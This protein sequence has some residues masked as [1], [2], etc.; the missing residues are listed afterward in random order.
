MHRALRLAVGNMIANTWTEGLPEWSKIG[1]T[2]L[3]PKG[4]PTCVHHFRPI[5][6]LNIVYKWK[7]AIV[8]RRM[9]DQD[10]LSDEQWGFRR[11]RCTAQAVAELGLKMDAYKSGYVILVDFQRAYNSVIWQTLWN[12]LESIGANSVS[13]KVFKDL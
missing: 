1:V 13:I 2:R 12:Q 7:A 3:L 8:A 10:I 6:L 11:G 4:K 9:R 5:S